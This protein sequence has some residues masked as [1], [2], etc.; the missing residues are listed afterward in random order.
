[1]FKANVK[2]TKLC[3]NPKDHKFAIAIKKKCWDEQPRDR[4][5]FTAACN[6]GSVV[7][8]VKTGK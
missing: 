5:T 2:S 4:T 6:Y 3:K 7:Q 1:M 8:N